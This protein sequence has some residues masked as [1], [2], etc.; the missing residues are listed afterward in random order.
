V[1]HINI[2]KKDFNIKKKE[3]LKR[4][5]LINQGK[6]GSIITSQREEEGNKTKK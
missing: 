4:K 3:K 1:F 6:E 2:K 5:L